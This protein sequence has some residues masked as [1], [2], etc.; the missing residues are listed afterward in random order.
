[1][2]QDWRL[3]AQEKWRRARWNLGVLCDLLGVY[4]WLPPLGPNIHHEVGHGGSVYISEISKYNSKFALLFCW[5]CRLK[6]MKK[7][8]NNAE[9][10]M[11]L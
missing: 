6:V 11:C 8:S 4:I 7:N 5:L 3:L 9:L 1:M 2:S 10:N